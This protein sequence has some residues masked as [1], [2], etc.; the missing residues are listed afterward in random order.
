MKRMRYIVMVCLVAVLALAVNMP[1]SSGQT[2]VQVYLDG[3]M[4]AFDQPPI[5][6]NDRTL[7]TLGEILAAL[8][9]DVSWD[10]ETSTVTAHK[11]QVE[12]KLQIGSKTA[13]VNNQAVE[14]DVPGKIVN[15]RT[16]VHSK[17]CQ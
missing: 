6:E 11:D 1:A 14:L 5:I 9:A 8:D 2:E 16:Q 7:I 15:D 3:S 4:L 13:Y 10:N 17:V 12:I